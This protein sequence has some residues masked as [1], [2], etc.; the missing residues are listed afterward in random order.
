MKKA[1][2]IKIKKQAA[3]RFSVVFSVCT[4]VGAVAGAGF[5]SGRELLEFYG[6]FRLFPLAVSFAAFAG[7]FFL[8]L[9]LGAK[10]GGFGNVMRGLFP[11]AA[12]H[13]AKIAALFGSFVVGAA[14]LSALNAAYPYKPLP[15]VLFLLI[16][17]LFTRRGISGVSSFGTAF[18]PFLI[19]AVLTLIVRRGSFSPPE[20]TDFPC[21]ARA[22]VSA[23]IYVG[24][25]VFATCPVLCD[26]G[27]TLAGKKRAAAVSFV[28]AGLLSLLAAAILSAVSSDKSSYAA[29]LPLDYVLNG[30]KFYSLISAV[31]MLTAFTACF[32]PVSVAAQKISLQKFVKASGVPVAEETFRA[33]KNAAKIVSAAAFFAVSALPFEALVRYF[34]PVAGVAGA[35]VIVAALCAALSKRRC[36]APRAAA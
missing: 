17:L 2:E 21:A 10:Y 7:G 29:P 8:F 26:L 11:G 23:A 28:S 34:Y 22:A 1:T 36:N 27:A 24:M 3:E 13:A 19:V 12:A 5:L 15:A 31:G 30:G 4:A 20:V 9:R 32:Y 25:N 33:R 18:T 35:A 14:T 16:A 6:G